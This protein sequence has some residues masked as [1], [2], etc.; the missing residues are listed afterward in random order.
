MIGVENRKLS[1][2]KGGNMVFSRL[3]KDCMD[4]VLPP[5]CAV[6][7]VRIP[8]SEYGFWNSAAGS[9]FLPDLRHGSV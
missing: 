5:G 4:I 3:A 1:K 9:S 2:Q 8:S 7:G 6:C